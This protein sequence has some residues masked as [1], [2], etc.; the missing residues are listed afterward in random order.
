[1]TKTQWI[2]LVLALSFVVGLQHYGLENEPETK[3]EAP[4]KRVAD[5]PASDVL[6]TY[7]AS[8]FFGA[9]RALAVDILWI[10]LRRV[11][12]EK[13]WYERREIV[14]LISYVQ[15]RNPEVWSHL[16]WHS[17]YNVA[18]GFTDP[19]KSW[20][21][22]KF[23]LLWLRKGI[24]TLPN[25]PYLKDQ[26]AYTLWHK[27]SWRDGEL[28]FPLLK[29]IESD[30]ELQA[31][32]RPEGVPADRPQTAFE[33]AMPWLAAARD[34]LLA[35]DQNLELTQVGL[36]LY[37]DGMDGFL[38]MCMILQ[39]MYDWKLNRTEEAKEWFRRAQRQ[40]D[41]ILARSPG[42]PV[43]PGFERKYRNSLS[44]IFNDWAELYKSYPQLVD[45]EVKA[46]SGR[47]EDQLE[48][49]RLLQGLLVKYGPIDEMWFW[50]RYNPRSLLN[51]TKLSLISD[52]KTRICP[53]IQEC[54]DSPD[55]GTDL[56][57]GDLALANLAPEGLDVDWYW[58][59]VAPPPEQKPPAEQ[60]PAPG[61]PPKPATV[62]VTL[63]RVGKLPLKVT[64]YDK[65]RHPIREELVSKEGATPIQFTTSDWGRYFLKVEA[66][67]ATH[68]WPADTRYKFQ[69]SVEF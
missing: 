23:G 5:L 13:R 44:S 68:P 59:A 42:T 8:L 29:R 7:L 32:L 61:H 3:A 40:V 30:P 35:R 45:L 12:E 22:V 62:T 58:L 64:I 9:F 53:D 55:M 31:A 14:K 47:R 20:E 38:R 37:P 56:N 15:P 63:T 65:S 48:L 26:L 16:G 52:P 27:P 39:G 6:P 1:M 36:Y 2:A 34:E 46:R 60:K 17:A 33:L 21:W 51:L 43:K 54:N 19:E 66:D 67:P 50:N 57:P 41:D 11:E 28:D 69:Y 4:M 25:E 10:Q 18:N 49:L 24:S